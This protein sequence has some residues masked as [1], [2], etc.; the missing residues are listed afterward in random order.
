[1]DPAKRSKWVC[2]TG[3]DLFIPNNETVLCSDHFEDHCFDRTG[4]TVRLREDSVP[5][6]FAGIRKRPGKCVT[7]LPLKRNFKMEA[8]SDSLSPG[9][10]SVISDH[11]YALACP[12]TAKKKIA[13]LQRQNETLKKTMKS[14]RQRERR[15][16]R[17][18]R[19][20]RDVLHELKSHFR[21]TPDKAEQML[22]NILSSLSLELLDGK[23]PHMSKR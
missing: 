8:D 10:P 5:T 19:A 16:A 14:N 4:Q 17:K 23:N 6:L 2:L 15:L 20:T 21:L 1:M 12:E 9:G 11:C 18:W 7:K 3:R 22:E 13:E